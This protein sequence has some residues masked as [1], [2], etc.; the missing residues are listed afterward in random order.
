MIKWDESWSIGDKLIDSQ[1]R[2]LVRLVNDLFSSGKET[3]ENISAALSFLANYTVTHFNDEEA[4]QRKH[5]FPGFEKH[6]Q[7]HSDFKAV[8]VDL[9]AKYE[10]TD[11]PEQLLNTIKKALVEWLV[12]HITIEDKKIGHYIESRNQK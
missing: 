1:H 8:V 5:R 2:E 12:N 7:V 6:K 9:L 11:S 4:L 10:T 3:R